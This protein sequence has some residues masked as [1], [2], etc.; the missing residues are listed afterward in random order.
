MS[1]Y[2]TKQKMDEMANAAGMSIR[3]RKGGWRDEEWNELGDYLY[4]LITGEEDYL[5]NRAVPVGHEWVVGWP[6]PRGLKIVP[7]KWSKRNG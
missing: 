7:A 2:W 5:T 3:H 1:K 4:Y 6:G